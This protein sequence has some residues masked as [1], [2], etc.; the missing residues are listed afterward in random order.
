MSPRKK[1]KKDTEAERSHLRCKEFLH[2]Q[3]RRKQEECT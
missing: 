1:K 3:T 2:L